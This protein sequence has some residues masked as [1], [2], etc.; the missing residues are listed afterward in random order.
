[1]LLEKEVVPQKLG[2]KRL[3]QAQC[4]PKTRKRVRSCKKKKKTVGGK[5]V[6]KQ[7]PWA[8]G[9]M[10]GKQ[11]EDGQNRFQDKKVAEQRSDPKGEEVSFIYRLR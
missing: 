11:A 1:M 10:A 2:K 4:F 9:W 5:W 6:R 3:S 8:G 7:E